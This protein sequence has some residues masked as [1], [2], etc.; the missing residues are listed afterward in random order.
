[1]PI[2][3][4]TLKPGSRKTGGGLYI[5]PAVRK[6]FKILEMMASQNRGYKLSAVARECSLP[7]STA[8]VLLHTLQECGYLQR[9]ENGA[10][11]LTTKLFTEGNKLIRQVQLYDVA[12]P[13]MQRL[14]RITGFSINL[15][16]PDRLELIYVRIIQGRGDIQVQ[17]HVGQRR[18]FHQAATGKAMLAFFPEERVK[19]ISETTGLPPITKRTI[20]SFRLLIKE[21]ELV[22]SQGFA[23]DN[24]ES[25]PSLWGVAAPIF[26]HQRNV[27]AALGVAGTVLSPTENAK[28][29]I[30]EIRKSSLAVSRALGYEPSGLKSTQYRIDSKT[31]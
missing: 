18:A 31:K 19:E 16:I 22:R 2:K 26:D 23:I 15:A 3:I 13:E 20:T 12:F 11:T 27:V 17:S 24:E 25:G 10:F 9:S 14:S 7:V 28:F 4:A 6:A 8:N 29:L 5:V 30:Q 1:M 21:L